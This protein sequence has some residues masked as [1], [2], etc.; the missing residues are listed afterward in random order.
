MVS[1]KL[2]ANDGV[3]GIQSCVTVYYVTCPGNLTVGSVYTDT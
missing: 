2:I 3:Q 1:N